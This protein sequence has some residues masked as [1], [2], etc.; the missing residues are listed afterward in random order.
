MKTLLKISLFSLIV[1]FQLNLH[2]EEKKQQETTNFESANHLT[3][4]IENFDEN[5]RSIALKSM[6]VMCAYFGLWQMHG[7]SL[8]LLFEFSEDYLKGFNFI[9]K[10][11]IVGSNVLIKIPLGFYLLNKGYNLVTKKTEKNKKRL[12][13]DALQ[14]TYKP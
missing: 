11:W 13:A 9:E 8:S 10:F 5:T 14:L 3:N 6:G 7:A 1:L 12:P 4:F 2:A